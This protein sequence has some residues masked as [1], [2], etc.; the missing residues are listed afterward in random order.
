MSPSKLS[1]ILSTRPPVA[2]DMPA[3][4][5]SATASSAAD[6]LKRLYSVY[7]QQTPYEYKLLSFPGPDNFPAMPNWKLAACD[8]TTYNWINKQRWKCTINV[9]AEVFF[10][11]ISMSFISCRIRPLAF[12]IKASVS[13]FSE[14]TRLRFLWGTVT[15]CNDIGNVWRMKSTR[16][17]PN[18]YCSSNTS[19]RPV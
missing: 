1:T 16:S 4:F 7:G 9:K 6:F 13:S 18:N 5:K 14:F 10:F 3:I 2:L 15:E 17:L 11:A 19:V 12:P 8:L